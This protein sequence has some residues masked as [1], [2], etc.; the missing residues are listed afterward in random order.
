MRRWRGEPAAASVGHVPGVRRHASRAG[1]TPSMSSR[2]SHG[3]GADS[4]FSQ[5]GRG[6]KMGPRRAYGLTWRPQRRAGCDGSMYIPAYLLMP[7]LLSLLHHHHHLSPTSLLLAL[8][9][10][11]QAR[12]EGRSARWQHADLCPVDGAIGSAIQ[13]PTGRR[14]SDRPLEQE[15]RSPAS[16]TL[17]AQ[18]QAPGGDGNEGFDP[19][20]CPLMS[21]GGA[22][23][24]EMATVEPLTC[25][26]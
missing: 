19:W 14:C 12:W 9:H 21:T 11:R 10:T 1:V 23:P 15:E 18:N 25:Q 20:A 8:S 24:V 17:H 4:C 2:E 26:T 7:L 5:M 16:A 13:E 22:S 6:T 3:D